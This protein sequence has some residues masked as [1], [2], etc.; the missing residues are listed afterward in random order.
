MG[1]VS[2]RESRANV[3]EPLRPVP[4]ATATDEP[5]PVDVPKARAARSDVGVRRLVV[6]LTPD[7]AVDTDR[8]KPGQRDALAGLLSHPSIRAFAT[9]PG[10]PAASALP[11]FVGAALVN[12][13]ATL[14]MLLVQRFTKAPPALV[15]DLAAWTPDEKAAVEP[16]ALAVANKYG[17]P[18][19]SKYGEEAALAVALVSITSNKIAAIR[20]ALDRMTPAPAPRP[21]EPPAPATSEPESAAS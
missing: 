19:L 13:L 21:V 11:S 3:G 2:R 6:P 20:D 15:R 7:G 4:A 17:G 5:V 8:L 12:A 16:A 18:L 14:D 9:E 10:D 1:R